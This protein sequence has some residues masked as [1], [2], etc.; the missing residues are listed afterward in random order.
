[1]DLW[2]LALVTLEY[3]SILC[4]HFSESEISPALASICKCFWSLICRNSEWAAS[5]S[6]VI[7][8]EFT[9]NLLVMLFSTVKYFFTQKGVFCSILSEMLEG[10]MHVMCME[11]T[12]ILYPF[13]L[14]KTLAHNPRVFIVFVCVGVS[15]W[16]LRLNSW[17]CLALQSVFFLIDSGLLPT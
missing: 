10:D 14:G 12:T 16:D 9:L 3:A 2:L 1:M 8:R 4:S 5:L 15:A 7:K 17:N 13:P 11:M 6:G